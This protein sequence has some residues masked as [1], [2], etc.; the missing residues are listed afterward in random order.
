MHNETS[1][2]IKARILTLRVKDEL[3]V[4]DDVSI[5]ENTIRNILRSWN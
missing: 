4:L 1:A 3:E 2:E 5:S